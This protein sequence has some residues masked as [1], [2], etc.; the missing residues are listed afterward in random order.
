MIVGQENPQ[1]KK[2]ACL[3]AGKL[4]FEST[5]GSGIDILTLFALSR[6]YP[7]PSHPPFSG[8]FT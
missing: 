8:S 4:T 2:P 6:F 5:H 1:Y 3:E 7:Y